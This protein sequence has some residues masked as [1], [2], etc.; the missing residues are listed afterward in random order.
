MDMARPIHLLRKQAKLCQ[1]QGQ[2]GDEEAYLQRILQLDPMD[3][4]AI[5][6]L[7]KIRLDQGFFA[8]SMALYRSAI[9]RC[10]GP[11]HSQLENWHGF[12][13][14]NYHCGCLEEAQK[15]ME[16]LIFFAGNHPEAHK[17]VA[18]YARIAFDSENYDAA[19]PWF[20]RALEMSQEPGEISLMIA[21]TLHN[22]R[23][24]EQAEKWYLR[25]IDDMGGSL[26]CQ[27][28][29]A[30]QLL[31]TGR[32]K[33][34]WDAYES[35]LKHFDLSDS[36]L[37]IFD[38]RFPLW[39]GEPLTDKTILVHGEQGIGDEIMFASVIPE[40][41]DLSR[42]VIIACT[43]SLVALFSQ[44]FPDALVL[45]HDRSRSAVQEWK[46]GGFPG[47]L[48]TISEPID[49]Q[50][51]IGALLKFFRPD[52][53]SFATSCDGYLV[54]DE[55]K[56]DYFVKQIDQRS[57]PSKLGRKRKVG[58]VWSANLSTGEM[59]RRKSIPIEM[60]EMLADNDT[61]FVSLQNQEFG[62]DYK[63]APRLDILD[64]SSDLSDF[65][66]TAGL[67]SACDLVISVDTSVAHLSG[68]LGRPTWIPLRQQSDW[69][70][71]LKREDCLWYSS[72]RLFRQEKEGDW[73]PV[74]TRIATEM[75]MID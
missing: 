44:S 57:K 58:L 64:F 11:L 60:L 61:Q 21:K 38:F 55:A 28:E 8:H 1:Q 13:V 22:Q 43:P 53:S 65:E 36:G 6:R 37:H 54:C 24:V 15:A 73:E 68:A 49:Y 7:A 4:D 31:L 2:P 33:A 32:F 17:L 23:D 9:V 47:W 74:L 5:L 35:R 41:I 3:C 71:L 25:A 70:Y 52:E 59:G 18:G 46:N 26:Y 40:L 75:K 67:V 45:P 51:P 42:Q 30:M 14:A 29:Y 50:A 63:R 19:L 16:K 20:V 12:A 69:R 72:T 56:R 48:N 62:L 39:E 66:M 10:A 34:G 27:W